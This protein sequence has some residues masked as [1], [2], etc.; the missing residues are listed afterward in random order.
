MCNDTGSG[1][2][3]TKK[4][5]QTSNH[6]YNHKQFPDFWARQTTSKSTNNNNNKNKTRPRLEKFLLQRNES[7]VKSTSRLESG[8]RRRAKRK[9][10]KRKEK[11]R[12]ENSP[13]L[14]GRGCWREARENA[15]ASTSLPQSFYFVFFSSDFFFFV[16]FALISI[17]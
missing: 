13:G 5:K 2:A 9:E 10:K 1:R 7:A 16:L 3:Q 4:Q 15:Q 6:H 14:L 8:R 17:V 12:K 11:K